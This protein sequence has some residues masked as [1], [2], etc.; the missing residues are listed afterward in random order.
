MSI[1]YIVNSYLHVMTY[2]SMHLG[3]FM[4]YSIIFSFL[5]TSWTQESQVHPLY[6][7]CT[8]QVCTLFIC[9]I[10]V[11]D[12]SVEY[13]HTYTKNLHILS[14]HLMYIYCICQ[15]SL[16]HHVYVLFQNVLKKFQGV[17]DS[18]REPHAH[19]KAETPL[20]HE[21]ECSYSF[22]C[23]IDVFFVISL[24]TSP[25]CWCRTSGVNVQC[26]HTKRVTCPARGPV[27]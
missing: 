2:I 17:G 21:C 22:L 1:V 8:S 15:Y 6:V 18:N 14:V 16:F 3:S 13:I 5:E 26:A 24:C 20:D 12:I 23:G 11:Q 9:L 25:A 4:H 10:L 27:V 7:P 19:C